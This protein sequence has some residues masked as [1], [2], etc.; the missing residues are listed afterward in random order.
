MNFHS[1]ML[2]LFVL[3][4]SLVGCWA[5]STKAAEEPGTQPGAK[6][7]NLV[8][9]QPPHPPQPVFY[10]PAKIAAKLLASPRTQASVSGSI[11][12]AAEAVRDAKG[13]EAKTAAQKHLS[14][15]LGKYFDDD[16]MRRQKELT[17]IEER[18]TKLRELL[19]RRRTKKQDILEL[20]MKVA[21]NEADGLGFYDGDQSGGPKRN[22][23]FYQTKIDGS[24]SN[25]FGGQNPYYSTP[26]P[27][28]VAPTGA[29]APP[30]APTPAAEPATGAILPR[31]K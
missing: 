21:L 18:L 24:D 19:E 15:L 16:M 14:E 28:V 2:C 20:Q 11:R 25:P 13:E 29:P 31:D 9:T 17:Q 10:G 22:D 8:P 27:A 23:Y 4:L 5:G 1:T 30:V 3:E 7:L 6:D 26:L 12:K